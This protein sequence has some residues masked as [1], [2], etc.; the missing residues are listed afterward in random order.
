MDTTYRNEPRRHWAVTLH[1]P[2]LDI[3][4]LTAGSPDDAEL[5]RRADQ[6]LRNYYA[7]WETKRNA[8]GRPYVQGATGQLERAPTT[9][10]YHYQL[11][12]RT[13]PLRRTQLYNIVRHASAEPARNLD[14]LKEYVQKEDTRVAGPWELP[15]RM[16]A[17]G[18]QGM[19]SDVHGLV[20]L[21]KEGTDDAT[22]IEQMP[23]VALQHF[24]NLT[25]LRTA[26]GV[27][28]PRPVDNPPNVYLYWG[29]SGAG[30]TKAAWELAGDANDVY[31]KGPGKW[32]DGYTQQNV[33]ILDDFNGKFF[34]NSQ[35]EDLAFLLRLLDRYPLKVEVKGSSID[36]NSPT[37][38]ITSNQRYEEWFKEITESTE[39]WTKAL[40]R[41]FT[42]IK[43]FSLHAFNQQEPG[44]LDDD[45]GFNPDLLFID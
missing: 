11:Y 41:R 8:R 39:E 30:K 14:A 43:H 5:A 17:R 25:G 29:E 44:P 20:E 23:R 12:L 28:K 36:F 1:P 16:L 4:E 6:M 15:T 40:K 9:G 33:V 32:W 7:E 37:I 3:G 24:R 31:I 35:K 13:E 18:G 19:R 22:I 38:V 45:L 2:E 21:L 10:G 27:Y 26:L 34:G 42:E